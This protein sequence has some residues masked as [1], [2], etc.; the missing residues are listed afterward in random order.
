MTISENRA[1]TQI[2]QTVPWSLHLIIFYCN[3]SDYDIKW[4]LIVQ[5]ILLYTVGLW[6]CS[7][8]RHF[9]HQTFQALS[10]YVIFRKW[11]STIINQRDHCIDVI[12]VAIKLFA[13]SGASI[14]DQVPIET[15]PVTF[16]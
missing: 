2:V 11:L 5:P 7:I 1:L 14:C 16:Y 6:K 4:H 3:L 9:N 10:T 12:I 13:S 8:L 15:E